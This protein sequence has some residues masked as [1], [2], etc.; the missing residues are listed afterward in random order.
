[1]RPRNKDV[2]RT[3]L[4]AFQNTH[5]AQLSKIEDLKKGV[6]YYVSSWEFA[7]SVGRKLVKLFGGSFNLSKKT[8]GRK[9]GKT[10][11]R[12]AILYRTMPFARGDVLSYEHKVFVISSVSKIVVGINLLSGK[13]ERLDLKLK[14]E[15]LKVHNT[16]VSKT[17]PL[18]VI[19]PEDYQSITIENVRK[20]IDGKVNVVIHQGRAYLVG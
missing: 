7:V 9:D 4:K 8:F 20:T 19:N 17:K 11:F 5:K 2:E 3:V 1:V 15:K 10:V 6:D 13:K 12:Y 18:E 16:V 14:Y